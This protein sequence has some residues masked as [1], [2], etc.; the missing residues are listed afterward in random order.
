MIELT[1][2]KDNVQIDDRDGKNFSFNE[3]IIL[4]VGGVKYETY[5]STLTAY[6][7][8]L[9]G[10]MFADRNLSLLYKTVDNEYFIDRN[11]HAFFY[12]LEFYRTGRLSWKEEEG[13][14]VCGTGRRLTVGNDRGNSSSSTPLSPLSPSSSISSSSSSTYLVTPHAMTPQPTKGSLYHSRVTREEFLSEVQYFQ[15]PAHTITSSFINRAAGQRLTHFMQSLEGVLHVLASEFQTSIRI[16]FRK[17]QLAPHIT[18]L[19]SDNEETMLKTAVIKI[20]KPHGSVGYVMLSTYGN[21]IKR[22]LESEI[23]GVTLEVSHVDNFNWFR[24]EMQ[25]D[26][27]ENNLVLENSLSIGA[28][29]LLRMHNNNVETR[30]IDI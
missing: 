16:D 30:F 26:G 8:T 4:N 1:G 27:L 3:R 12:I 5:R 6:P 25:I 9:L 7:N 29:D 18:I 10:T 22:Y 21:E 17:N 20:I 23:E 28:T 13:N 2:K 11:G 14:C 15:L 24:L 19:S